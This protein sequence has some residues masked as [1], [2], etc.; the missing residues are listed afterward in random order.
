MRNKTIC[1]IHMQNIEAIKHY[2]WQPAF[3]FVS[4]SE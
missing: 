1:S 3:Q 2:P 4:V